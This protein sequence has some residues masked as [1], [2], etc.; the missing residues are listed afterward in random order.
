[1]ILE[2]QS[3]SI[4]Y[5]T[6][7]AKG[8]IDMS[9]DLDSAQILMQMLSKNLYSDAVGSTIRECASNALDSHRRAGVDDP[10]IVSLREVSNGYEF[11]VEDFGIG[12]DADDVEKIISKYG[13]S[14][15]RDSNTELGMMGLGFKAPLAYASSFY[16]VCR[17]DGVERKYMMYEGE[18][19]NA[20]D[21]LLETPTSERNGVKV[22][23]P[24]KYSD[25]HSFKTKIREQLAYFESVHFD[26]EDID[27][28]FSIYRGE[29]YQMSELCQTNTMHICLDNVY[30]PIDWEKLG[31]SKIN[32][33]IGLRFGLSDGIFPTPNRESL[34]YNAEMKQN[35]LDKIELVADELVDKYNETVATE[36]DLRELFVF[37]STNEIE[38]PSPIDDDAFIRVTDLVKRS[39]KACKQPKLKDCVLLNSRML[40][41]KRDYIFVDY[42]HRHSFQRY[43]RTIS[44][45]KS[46]YDKR[47]TFT[48]H[49][50]HNG[51][52]I[53]NTYLFDTVLGST[54][55]TYLRSNCKDD[56]WFVKKGA[57]M[58]LWS[59]AYGKP[60]Q[61]NSGTYYGLLEL[62]KYPKKRW[63]DMIIELQTIKKSI[64]DKLKHVSEIQIPDAWIAAQ[65]ASK[66]K[67][68]KIGATIIRERGDINVK[69]LEPL[70]RWVDSQN[71]KFV[72]YV[73]KGKDLDVTKSIIVYGEPDKKA[74]LDRL[75]GL[76]NETEAKFVM[77]SERDKKILESYGLKHWVHVDKFVNDKH[78]VYR[79]AITA[80]A[81]HK[82]LSRSTV[83]ERAR[84]IDE[85]YI[86]EGLKNDVDTLTSFRKKH[87]LRISD[88]DFRNRVD[89][90]A[91]VE[92]GCLCPTVAD[93][94]NR[95][96]A[97]IN[98]YTFISL[99]ATD[100]TYGRVREYVDMLEQLC[101]RN[102]IRMIRSRYNITEGYVPTDEFGQLCLFGMAS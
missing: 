45:H 14:T 88:Y 15:K 63:R 32:V 37:Y 102:H 77:V 5:E 21:L 25:R 57:P 28:S 93:V 26:V 9:L 64:T 20:I 74:L 17:K 1:M 92:R 23:V 99:V 97:L 62:W 84:N 24:V 75:Y 80:H 43:R 78:R 61:S 49:R 4:I 68:G 90:D 16:F 12:L 100:I 86:I 11:S 22:V 79:R 98:E 30:Y 47:V 81:I 58:K 33:P 27:N 31:I 72:S 13:K 40:Y 38:I 8:S 36:A 70:Q 6:G 44:H 42:E 85:F 2:K 91:E 69:L 19:T 83:F 29:H 76:I 54:M 3:Q 53:P 87:K 56:M 55:Q 41:L 18:D 50:Q 82:N 94:Y 7:A 89:I 39:K 34:R 66:K 95:V 73:W 60:D 71:G 96:K 101:R 65:K 52:F 67:P 48:V 35:I 51:W 46:D 10:I 59:F